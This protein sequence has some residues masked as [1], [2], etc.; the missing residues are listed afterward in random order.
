MVVILIG[1]VSFNLIKYVETNHKKY[2]EIVK[3]CKRLL[4]SITSFLLIV[5]NEVSREFNTQ[6]NFLFSI[7][8]TKEDNFEKCVEFTLLHRATANLLSCL[9]EL[10]PIE[11]KK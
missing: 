6:I 8:I 5:V 7:L 3:S 9:S 10:T 1:K 4:E 2:P 11:L